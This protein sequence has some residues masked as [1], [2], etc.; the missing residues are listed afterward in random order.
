MTARAD[1]PHFIPPIKKWLEKHGIGNLKITNQK[2]MDMIVL[3]DDR[4]V[5]VI[6]N[7]GKLVGAEED[8]K[9]MKDSLEIFHLDNPEE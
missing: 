3:F 4:A 7:T 1:K 9:S 5:Q 2:D 8:V 6:P